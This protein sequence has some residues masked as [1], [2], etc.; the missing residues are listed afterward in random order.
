[1][2]VVVEVVLPLQLL[3]LLFQQLV[4]LL[5]QVHYPRLYL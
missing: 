1:M 3:V 2:V 5:L 4:L